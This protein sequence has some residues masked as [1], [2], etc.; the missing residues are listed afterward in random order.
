MADSDTRGAKDCV[1][2]FD[3]RDKKPL[4][5]VTRLQELKK[6]QKQ[7]EVQT[8]KS[9]E[10]EQKK[11]MDLQNKLNDCNK[12]YADRKRE[13]DV[14][15]N[16]QSEKLNSVQQLDINR[17]TLKTV[18]SFLQRRPRLPGGEERPVDVDVHYLPSMEAGQSLRVGG[19][20]AG[21]RDATFPVVLSDNV[22]SLA[23]R[24]AT[25]W[26]LDADKVFFL[27]RDGRIVFEDMSLREII[28]PPTHHSSSSSSAAASSAMALENGGSAGQ[29][30]SAS[31]SQ[32]VKYSDEDARGPADAPME[33]W[34]VKGRNYNLTLVRAVR[35]GEMPSAASVN[36]P[37]GEEWQDFTFDSK[38]LAQDLKD[39]LAKYGDPEFE[40]SKIQ[41][42]DIPSLYDLI[43]T[44][45]EK[46]A[47]KRADTFC[48]AVEFIIFLAC[49][50]AYHSLIVPAYSWSTTMQ[51]I[52]AGLERHLELF[53][54]NE[55]DAL[56]IESY[57]NIASEMQVQ[58][59]IDGPLKRSV[60]PTGLQ[61][62]NLYV[63]GLRGIRYQAA[64]KDVEPPKSW[65]PAPS[66]PA[67]APLP[68]AGISSTTPAVTNASGANASNATSNATGNTTAPNVSTTMSLPSSTVLMTTASTAAALPDGCS[69][70]ILKSCLNTRVVDV[71]T[72]A[73]KDGDT[74]PKCSRLF[75]KDAALSYMDSLTGA[76]QFT[77]SRGE[78]SSYYG[79][80][81]TIIMTN[82]ATDFTRTVA[83]MTINAADVSTPARKFL[84][85][86]Y[87]PSL[88]GVFVYR[89]L[90]E[91][92]QTGGLVASRKHIVINLDPSFEVSI[93]VY[94]VCIAMAIIVLA[95]EVRRILGCPKICTFEQTRDH[96]S[97]WTFISLLV[98]IAMTS[99]FAVFLV[100]YNGASDKMLQLGSDQSL[101][102][103][104]IGSLFT[105]VQMEYYGRLLNMTVLAFLNVLLFRYALMYFPQLSF[106][107][108]MV[109]KLV[110][111]L[112]YTTLFLVV[113]FTAFTTILYV[114]YSTQE[115]SFRDMVISFCQAIIFA[116]GGFHG[117]QGV[118]SVYPTLFPIIMTLGFFI[119]QLMLKNVA[120]AIMLSHKKEKDLRQNYSYHRFWAAEISK[121]GKSKEE[122]N[123][124]MM[125]N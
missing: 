58:A 31:G 69:P 35:P 6:E 28:L 104:S 44:G 109:A 111:P 98:P 57:F 114:L 3:P 29:G 42:D 9:L 96:C 72:E 39:T 87:S 37:K 68:V 125:G 70:D 120:L 73:L 1:E 16:S 4:A 85:F 92:S 34:T 64:S 32:V 18:D 117:W 26:G 7:L 55:T 76:D 27:D 116:Q 81:Q 67:P 22:S 90:V 113:A 2:G 48:R 19:E 82:N 94:S 45:K 101:S 102:D 38:K 10:N 79:G 41:M 52:S 89:M 124:A 106:L 13:L 100:R 71:F 105:Q 77:Y 30:G 12:A 107:K 91:N 33:Q 83:A 119:I 59:W 60:L 84:L 24:A 108:T 36:K 15:R 103:E 53:N 17:Q 23:K 25:Y 75:G 14:L 80:S 123:P 115:K 95:M 43:Q 61:S 122:F 86:V 66:P 5:K 51:L 97:C 93:I 121:K 56:G 11:V 8:K 110:K 50:A 112:W 20:G 21:S 62:R 118:Y 65:C 88:N 47:K 99:A 74:V 40:E 54:S 49:F 78:V 63:L 46:K